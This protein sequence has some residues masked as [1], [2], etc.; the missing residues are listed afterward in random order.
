MYKNCNFGENFPFPKNSIKNLAREKIF[1]KVVS[2]P[3]KG[4]EQ[5]F[6]IG[7]I[8]PLTYLLTPLFN[9]TCAANKLEA[10]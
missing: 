1:Q 8:V 4:V 2:T 6:R 9:V 7:K 3:N 10:R 5:I